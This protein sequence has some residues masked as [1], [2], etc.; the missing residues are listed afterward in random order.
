MPLTK[1][2]GIELIKLAR[3]SINSYLN[4]TSIKLTK[5]FKELYLKGKNDENL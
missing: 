1:T 4:K 3:Q 2:Q 5:E